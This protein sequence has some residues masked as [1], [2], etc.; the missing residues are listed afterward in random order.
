MNGKK[1]RVGVSLLVGNMD[2]MV[3]FYRDILGFH[4]QWDGGPFADFET[5]SGDLSLFMY[6]REEFVKAIGEDYIPP[7]GINQTFEIALWLPGFADVDLEYARLS[8]WV[9]NSQQENLLPILSASAT[10]M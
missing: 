5:G 3:R 7:R 1:V 8:S 4:T 10:F 2:N 9:C 6:S